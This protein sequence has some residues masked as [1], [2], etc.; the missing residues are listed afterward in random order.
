VDTCAI[1]NIG[2]VAG[3]GDLRI[4]SGPGGIGRLD[5]RAEECPDGV[6]FFTHIV[7]LDRICRRNKRASPVCLFFGARIL[8]AGA[9]GEIHRLHIARSSA[10]DFLAKGKTDWPERTFGDRSFHRRGGGSRSDGCLVGKVSS[11]HANACILGANRA[12]VDREPRSLVLSRQDILAF[13]S[14]LHLSAV[15]D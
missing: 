5:F 14:H 15:A 10:F 11:R 3:R 2:R 9:V 13:K 6:L 7:G 4:P 8:S 12:I 1:E